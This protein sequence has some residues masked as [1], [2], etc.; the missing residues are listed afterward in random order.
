MKTR[1][2]LCLLFALLALSA[3]GTLGASV[4]T[5]IAPQV[6]TDVAE[7]VRTQVPALL[8]ATAAPAYDCVKLTCDK[9]A[10]CQEAAHKLNA[11]GHSYLDGDKD[12]IPCEAFCRASD[13]PDR[14]TALPPT[15][16]PTAAPQ[17]PLESGPVIRVVDGDTI[18][19][20]LDGRNTRVRYL[21][22][23]TP[24]RDEPCGR[25]ATAANA[26][27]VQAE[28]VSLVPDTELFDRYGRLLRFV[29][30]DELLVNRALV[31]RGYAE[32]VLYPPNNARYDEFR[33]LEAEA[34]AAGRGCHP[35]GIFDD[36]SS[37]R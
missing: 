21:Q 19:V 15:A 6:S 4:S 32:V 27:F 36:G 5:K 30:V 22:V 3:C 10:S 28:V 35:T 14:P 18:D 33:A 29:Y 9:I 26:A 34:A 11:C 23:N 17:S 7:Q 24:E 13:F 31:E 20:L 25:D 2:L 1:R 16:V 37:T 12:G 8:N